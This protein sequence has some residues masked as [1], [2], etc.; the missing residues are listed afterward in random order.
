MTNNNKTTTGF[1]L[2]QV[3]PSRD[4]EFLDTAMEFPMVKE[5]HLVTGTAD[6][7]LIVEG[8]DENE[9]HDFVMRELRSVRDVKVTNTFVSTS[10]EMMA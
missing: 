9:I 2:V 4:H 5:G 7:F 1:I 10:V 6:A 3:E 8:R